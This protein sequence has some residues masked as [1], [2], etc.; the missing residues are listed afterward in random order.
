MASP[1]LEQQMRLAIRTHFQ[2]LEDALIEQMRLYAE[3]M[4]AEADRLNEINDSLTEALRS[5]HQ[6]DGACSCELCMQRHRDGVR[7]P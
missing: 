6:D 5:I 7:C 3:R 1:E 2:A 4:E